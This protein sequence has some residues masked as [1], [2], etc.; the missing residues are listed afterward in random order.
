M[1]LPRLSSATLLLIGLNVAVWLLQVASGVPPLHP[2]SPALIA[3][4]GNLP[5]YAL[6][7]DSWRLL[8]AMFVHGG[9]LHLGLNMLAL[10]F[11]ADRTEHEFGTAR[12]LTIYVAGGVLASCASVLWSEWRATPSNSTALLRVSVGASGAVMAQFGALLVALVVTPPRFVPLPPEER[13]GVDPGLVLVVLANLAFGFFVP[14]VD[15][16]AHVGGL[17][18]GIAIGALMAMVPTATGTRAALARHCAAALLVVACVGALLHAAPHERLLALRA[19]WPWQ[20][21]SMR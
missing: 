10:S 7:G 18:G 13:P 4:G 21:A 6:T 17:L 20:Q 5:L 15:Q 1:E 8:T 12:M 3:W 11:T 9:A 16:A 2:A 14:H 19:Q